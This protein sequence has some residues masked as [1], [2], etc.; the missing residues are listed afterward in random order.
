[1]RSAVVMDCPACGRSYR[2]RP[3]YFG[4]H[5]KCVRCQHRFFVPIPDDCLEDTVFRWLIEGGSE[6][7]GEPAAG[8][9]TPRR[10]DAG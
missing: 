1:M 10:H 8:P 4:L 2:I 9:S 7:D 6:E 5:I 3:K